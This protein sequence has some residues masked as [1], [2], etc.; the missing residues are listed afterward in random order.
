MLWLVNLVFLGPIAV[1]AA[2][3]GGAT[4]RIDINNMPWLQALLWAPIVEELVFRYWLRRPVNAWWVL[5]AAIG[6]ML[7]GPKWPAVFALA[8]LLLLCWRPMLIGRKAPMRRPAFPHASPAEKEA[9][10][11]GDDTAAPAGAAA[12]ATSAYM[13]REMP[14]ASGLPGG[15]RRRLGPDW[16]WGLQPTPWRYRRAYLRLFPLMF[17][18]ASLA[19]AAVHL[20]NFN[21]HQT[22]WWLLPLLVLPQWVTGLVLGWMRVRRGIGASMLLHGAFNGGPLLVVWLLLQFTDIATQAM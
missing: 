11:A 2:G 6:I 4:H 8:A 20:Y 3:L 9:V 5:P 21:L 7:S 14:E 10:V 18:L 19:F 13:T 22:P 17:H 12:G 1:S 15:K 16:L